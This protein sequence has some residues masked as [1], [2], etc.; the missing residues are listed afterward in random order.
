MFFWTSDA[1]HPSVAEWPAS[2]EATLCPRGLRNGETSWVL[3]SCVT[4]AIG[5]NGQ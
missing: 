1:G 2:R 5:P 3:E 4:R